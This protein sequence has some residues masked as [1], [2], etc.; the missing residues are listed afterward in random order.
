MA[1]AVL[2]FAYFDHQ[3]IKKDDIY[4]Q[5]SSRMGKTIRR[6]NCLASCHRRF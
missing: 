6:I 5:I 4:E 1:K 3:T 2:P